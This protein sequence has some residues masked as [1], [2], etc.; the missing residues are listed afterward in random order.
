MHQRHKKPANHTLKVFHFSG[1]QIRY[2]VRHFC[3]KPR[4]NLSAHDWQNL[5]GPSPNVRN[6]LKKMFRA[7]NDIR[8]RLENLFGVR[9]EI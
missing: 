2:I 8:Q 1:T 9:V 7:R 3:L 5:I 6:L 4:A